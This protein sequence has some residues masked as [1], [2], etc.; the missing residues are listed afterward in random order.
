MSAPSVS[1]RLDE[2]LAESASSVHEREIGAF[3][4][5]AGSRGDRIVLWGAG[6]LG[7][8]T[9]A[10]LQKL[11]IGPVAFCDSN[12]SLWG[13]HVDGV[14]VLSPEGAAARYGENALFVITIWGPHDRETM[15]ARRQYLAGLGC[16]AV[17]SFAPLF[18]KYPDV[19]G[20]YYSFS[21]PHRTAEQ[22]A[23]ILSAFDLWADDTSRAEFV[24]Q[25]EW[26]LRGDFDVLR[27]RA[28]HEIYFPTDLVTIRPD[29]LFVDCGAYDGDTIRS[30]FRRENPAACRVVAFEPDPGPF[31]KLQEWVLSLKSDARQRIE[32]HQTAIGA[33][34][35]S[36]RFDPTADEASTVGAGSALVACTTL[37]TALAG[38][39]PGYIKMDIEGWEPEAIAGGRDTIAKARPVMAVCVYHEY[40]HVWRIPL[41]IAGI[42]D[43]Y[44]F[45]LR[46]HHLEAWDLVCYAIPSERLK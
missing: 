19:F 29:E 21:P 14:P 40:D 1:Q 38:R 15:T 27:S 33:T 44:R 10:G 20:S 24:A 5:G 3:I 18:W 6:R 34:A 41:A 35:G 12:R 16:T 25:I 45:F 39:N 26:R 23:H 22:A 13:T 46:P 43:Q 9:S 28:S 8:K 32:L 17:D 2:L 11:G 7:R 4:Q 31:Q 36:I 42:A 37:D 30:L